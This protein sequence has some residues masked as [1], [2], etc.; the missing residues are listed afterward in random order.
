MPDSRD[1]NKAVARQ[2]M[3]AWNQRGETHIPQELARRLGA[4][5]G[6]SQAALPG[7]AIQGQQFQED[8]LLADNQ[9]AFMA[10]SMTGQHRGPL[11]GRAGTNAPV[12]VHGADLFRVVDGQVTEHWDWY[13]KARIQALGQL[14]LLDVR[15]Q[16]QLIRDNLLGRNRKLA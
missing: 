7:S 4:T 14:G 15:M 13:S 6:Q 9:F 2:I 8:I 3:S 12:T 10:W 5:P 16:S 1:T 11:Y